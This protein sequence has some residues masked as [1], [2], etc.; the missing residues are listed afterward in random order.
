M[1]SISSEDSNTDNEFDTMGNLPYSPSLRHQREFG[2]L[3]PRSASHSPSPTQRTQL[4]SS[5]PRSPSPSSPTHRTQLQNSSPRSLSPSA[6][7]NLQAQNEF[8]SSVGYTDNVFQSLMDTLNSTMASINTPASP[9]ALDC[10]SDFQPK[11]TFSV[12]GQPIPEIR[13]TV[14][15]SEVSEEEEY[16]LRSCTSEEKYKYTTLTRVR[17]LEMSAFS[18]VGRGDPRGRT[19]KNNRG[20]A[21]RGRPSVLS[22]WEKDEF[23][24]D[25]GEGSEMGAIAEVSPYDEEGDVETST[26]QEAVDWTDWDAV[27]PDC[28]IYYTE[29]AYN[30]FWANEENADVQDDAQF[31]NVEGVSEVD[32]SDWDAVH[33]DCEI[34]YRE[35]W[36]NRLWDQYLRSQEEGADDAASEVEDA[37]VVGFE[38]RELEEPQASPRFEPRALPDMQST[39]LEVPKKSN[40]SPV[41]SLQPSG[42]MTLTPTSSSKESPSPRNS[43]RRLKRA[44]SK[45]PSESSTK[46]KHKKHEKEKEKEKEK[47]RE[48][49][50]KATEEKK[51]SHLDKINT[52]IEDLK[53]I[54]EF[55]R[56]LKERI[57]KVMQE[58]PDNVVKVFPLTLFFF[59][60]HAFL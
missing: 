49:N 40:I 46:I 5:S 42:N 9:I 21:Y 6:S 8:G 48:K 32:W 18:G 13:T 55:E 56:T 50:E 43:L 10:T 2:S 16:K 27:H 34:Y 37:P 28:E 23:G 57:E 11:T 38:P 44:S 30:A 53:T 52:E 19:L 35:D 33:P 39:T 20:S 26:S 59:H 7:S 25:G 54:A 45:S 36:Y 3:D 29:E 14:A 58:N 4:R 12:K 31:E 22:M 60:S 51:S 41:I 1:D 24:A 15:S 17:G 47:E